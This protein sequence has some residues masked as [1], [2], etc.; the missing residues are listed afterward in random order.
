MNFIVVC[1]RVSYLCIVALGR[2]SSKHFLSQYFCLCILNHIIGY[3]E[4]ASYNQ[5]LFIAYKFVNVRRKYFSANNYIY[6]DFHPDILLS[7]KF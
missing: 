4:M 5:G 6:P 7:S 2:K 3:K 1:V